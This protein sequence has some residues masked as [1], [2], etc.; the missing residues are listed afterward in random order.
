MENRDL[1]RH[2]SVHT[3][4]AAFQCQE[5]GQGFTLK[6]SLLTHMRNKHLG[7]KPVTCPYCAQSFLSPSA[8]FRHR[9]A[10]AGGHGGGAAAVDAGEPDADRVKEEPTS[11][12]LDTND[13]T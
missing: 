3:G 13:L 12:D 5:C 1:V 7:H 9:K 2:R 6:A 11:M 10:C 8:L 4:Q